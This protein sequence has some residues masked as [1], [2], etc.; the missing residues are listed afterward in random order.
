L[1]DRGMGMLDYVPSVVSPPG[2]TLLETIEALGMTQLE[3]SQR[4][5]RPVK[6]INEII[7]GKTAI[8][9]E[10]ALQLERVLGVPAHFWRNREEQYQQYLLAQKDEAEL[11]E[12]GDWLKEIPF[13]C[14]VKL[15]WVKDGAND[16]ERVKAGLEYFGVASVD[17]WR[18]IWGSPAAAYRQSLAFEADPG[19]VAAWL[20][21]GE[22]EAWAMECSPYRKKAFAAVLEKIRSLTVEQPGVFIPKMQSLCAQAGVAVVFVPELPKCRASGAARWL[23]RGKALVQLSLRYKTNDHLWFTFFHEAAHVLGG[24]RSLTFIDEFG[25][26][27]L[28]SKEEVQADRFAADI[29]IPPAEYSRFTEGKRGELISRK[30]VVEFAKSIEVAPGI[31]VGRLQHDKLLPYT[32]LN[33]LKVQLKWTT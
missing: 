4:M 16:V 5:G 28:A 29:L 7:N 32:H 14:L 26:K 31:V 23:N 17:A 18:S 2:D 1:T 8:T 11:A 33:G 6:T 20:R 27:D 13:R 3:L 19:A 15:G 12:C 25:S 10:T 24:D 30:E 21:K 22:I 9:P